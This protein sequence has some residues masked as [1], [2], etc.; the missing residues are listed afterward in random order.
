[1]RSSNWSSP[2]GFWGD[3]AHSVGPQPPAPSSVLSASLYYYCI[4]AGCFFFFFVFFMNTPTACGRSQVSGRIGATAAGLCH[5]Y[6]NARSELH[7]WRDVA[8]CD[9]TGYLTHWVRPGIKPTPILMDTTWVPNHWPMMGTPRCI[10]D[11]GPISL[12]RHLIGPWENMASLPWQM[13]GVQF[14]PSHIAL[15]L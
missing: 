8:T 5:S 10:F 6:G 15:L 3:E 12:P 9:N 13:V 11:W 7:L 2:W 1:M 4:Q 14:D